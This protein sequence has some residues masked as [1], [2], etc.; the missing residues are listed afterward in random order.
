MSKYS[1]QKK[2]SY[3]IPT[4]IVVAGILIAIG[5]MSSGSDSASA[6]EVRSIQKNDHVRGNRED[7]TV[8]IVEFSDY[9]CPFC[10]RLHPTLT[11]I[12]EEND[13]VAWVYRH[14]PIASHVQAAR[15]AGA[16]E[17]AGLLGGEKAFWDFTDTFF[18]KQNSVRPEL[19]QELAKQ[20]GIDAVAFET[21]QSSRDVAQ[22][23]RTD[24]REAQNAGLQGTPYSVIITSSGKFLPFNGALA[25]EQVL[26]L[27]EEAR[28]N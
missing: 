18:E 4:A 15:A 16:A 20:N 14:Y 24:A 22:K 7:P 1:S 12:I 23:I 11:R 17:C 27:V 21:C 9:Q 8:T 19:F 2:P 10:A 6:I 5:F 28:V 26:G 25:Y 3:A 13:D